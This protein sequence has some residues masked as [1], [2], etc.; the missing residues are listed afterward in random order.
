VKA[1]GAFTLIELLVVMA[2][3]ALLVG[4]LLPAL[5][6]ARESGRA[7][8]CASNL[9][10]L[11]AA[12]D[13]YADAEAGFYPPGAAGIAENNLQRWHGS[14]TNVNEPF[15]PE[16]GSLTPYIGDNNSSTIIRACPSF[17]DVLDN[18]DA[19]ER[20]CGGYGYNNAYVG[21]QRKR[22]EG[23][24]WILITDRSGAAR[25]LFS[26]PARTVAF[27]DSA[28]AGENLIEYSFSEPRFHPDYPG[29]RLDPSQHFRHQG[30][31]N[32][33]WLDGHVSREAMAFTWSSGLYRLS[34]AAVDV[35]WFGKTDDDSIY[36]PDG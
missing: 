7:V 8:V 11:V 30:K 32:A 22:T 25:H 34:A 26:H 20:G 15:T 5:G 27:T 23:D 1:R 6:A 9:R 18:P 29:V 33:A 36:Q 19:F 10:Q 2:V 13:L 16:G 4:M 17:I 31:L 28:F 24:R 12:V 35:G 3:I 21:T 14:R